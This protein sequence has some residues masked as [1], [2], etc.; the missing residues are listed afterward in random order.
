MPAAHDQSDP[1]SIGDLIRWPLG[2]GAESIALV[3]EVGAVVGWRT[4]ILALALP[5]HSQPV[6]PATFRM[7]RADDLFAAGL[8]APVR[9]EL[10]RG[11]SVSP[12]HPCLLTG[13]SPLLGRLSGTA[14]DRLNDA[15]ARLH[16][17]RDIAA[18]R[19]EERRG[20][21]RTAWRPQP[22]ASA[23]STKEVS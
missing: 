4:L 17:L 23:I 12:R 21:R 5:D 20:D 22:R 3:V 10:D 15:R 8:A 11:V 2:G 19:R 6:R 18:A 16:A 9:F 1:I 13:A 14:L 7:T